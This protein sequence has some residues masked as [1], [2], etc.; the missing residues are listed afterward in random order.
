MMTV[1]E[2]D[3][4]ACLPETV[5]VDRGA[6]GGVNEDGLCWSLDRETA[7]R[8][9][10]YMRYRAKCPVLV[11]GRVQRAHIIALK[12]DRA[13]SE[14]L[15][16]AVRKIAVEPVSGERDWVGGSFQDGKTGICTMYGRAAHVRARSAARRGG[17]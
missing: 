2:R 10:F 16:W 1:E 12:L 7:S 11:T 3:R 13:E 8:V 9:L 5:T 6:D 4:L 14:V 15:S 17:A